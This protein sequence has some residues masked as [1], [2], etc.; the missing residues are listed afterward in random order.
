MLS[1]E[2]AI[3]A[4]LD[5]ADALTPE[6]VSLHDLS[7]RIAAEDIHALITQPPFAASAMDGYAVRFADVSIG[8]ELKVIGE[9]PAGSPFVGKVGEGE[10][11]RI[12][13]GGAVPHGADHVIIQ[14]DVIRD[15][16]QIRIS[17]AQ[18][19]PGN[20]R[21]AGIDFKKGD[22]LIR[23]GER[24]HDIHGAILA[25]ANI[26]RISV[27]RRPKIALFSNGDEL[28]EPGAELNPGQIVNSNHYALS[29]MIRAWGGEPDYLGRASDDENAICSFFRKASDADLIVPIGG[30]SVGDYDFVKSA[31][32]KEG[33]DIVFE[34]VAV[35]PGKPTWFGNPA[36]AI[37]TAAL[38]VQPLVRRLA[39]ESKVGAPVFHQAELLTPL[40]AN[41]A[42]ESYLRSEAVRASTGLA[43]SAAANQDSSL[44]S[45]FS[46]ANCLIRRLANAKAAANGDTVEIVWLR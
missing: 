45:P 2:E 37:V 26:S 17:D 41:S 42:R 10:A 33:G 29:A 8:A 22:V 13:T 1:V 32:K 12:F 39:G 3:A 27:V 21:P 46:K 25:A 30:A 15:G 19:K 18:D 31:F 36:S 9:S 4:I 7:S 20:I 23:A 11:V 34:K 14:E 16:A 28:V 44:L 5:G 24:M 40:K 6:T 43:V 35:R 38:F